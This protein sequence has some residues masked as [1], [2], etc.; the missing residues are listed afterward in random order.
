MVCGRKHCVWMFGADTL[1]NAKIMGF[2]CLNDILPYI[3][4]RGE[5]VRI[6]HGKLSVN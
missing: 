1:C 2:I 3:G 5:Y 4:T 6:G